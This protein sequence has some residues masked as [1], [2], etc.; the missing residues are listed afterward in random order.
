MKINF[1][2]QF[3][4]SEVYTAYATMTTTNLNA[5]VNLTDNNNRQWYIGTM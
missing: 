5:V 2:I 3:K 4:T 1:Y